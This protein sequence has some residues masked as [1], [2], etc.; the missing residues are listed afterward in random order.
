MDSQ[1][2]SREPEK[3]D[4]VEGLMI[5]WR[6][7][8]G[9]IDGNAGGAELW[10]NSQKGHKKTLPPEAGEPLINQRKPEDTE[11]GY[12]QEAYWQ[13]NCRNRSVPRSR[14]NHKCGRDHPGRD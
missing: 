4:D 5:G 1:N 13:L 7:M 14:D 12:L 8:N 10:G 2:C 9:D 6:N 11:A 3:R